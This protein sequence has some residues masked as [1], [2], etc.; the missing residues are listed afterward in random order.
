ENRPD[1][2]QADPGRRNLATCS[3]RKTD[4]A[5]NQYNS[6]ERVNVPTSNFLKRKMK[7]EQE[8]EKQELR[9]PSQYKIQKTARD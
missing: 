4:H 7:R 8:K 9:E 2:K 1:Q 3:F 5:T 6:A